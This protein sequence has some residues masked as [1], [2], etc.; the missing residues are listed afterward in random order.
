MIVFLLVRFI[1]GN[2][3]DVIQAQMAAQNG[4]TIDRA[5]I[6]KLLGL[7][8]PVYVQY[9]H[10]V[11][12]IVLHGNLGM[13]LISSQ[14]ITPMLLQRIPLTFE[15]GFLG[16]LVGFIISIPIGIYAAMR[17]DTI[18]D[19]V[20]RSIIIL[21][22]SVPNFLVAYIFLYYASVIW[23]W[24]PQLE[25]IP[26]FTNPLGNLGMM[27][28]PAIFLGTQQTGGYMRM[29]RTMMLETLRQDYIRTAWAKGLSERVVVLRHAMKNALIPVVEMVG[30]GIPI[31][32]GGAV[33]IENIFNLAGTGRLMFDAINQRDY[34][35]IS[36]IT[37]IMSVI[38]ILGNLVM[39]LTYG[40]LDPRIHY[41]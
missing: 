16:I 14:P 2:V 6:I 24:I 20:L 33:L 26:F 30:G 27:I 22:I 12:G 18:Q 9:A 5:A 23:H 39:D 32:I 4:G 3:I 40:W 37:L 19:R 31:L 28:I 41:Q 7:N 13:S 25:F 35:V 11:T 21:L 10:W 1:P 17:Q 8:V 34:P 15:L 38:V 29:M 36:A